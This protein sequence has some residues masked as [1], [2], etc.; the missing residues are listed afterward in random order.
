MDHF[1]AV[2]V[3]HFYSVANTR[4][5]ATAVVEHRDY[6]DGHTKLDDV[7]A[8]DDKVVLR[9]SVFGTYVGEER[10]GGPKKGQRFASAAIAIY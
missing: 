7:F 6:K 5:L 8:V 2:R 9:F 4:Q 10:P 1:F 3:D